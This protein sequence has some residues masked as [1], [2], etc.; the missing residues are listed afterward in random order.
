MNRPGT[1]KFFHEILPY[2]KTEY[3]DTANNEKAVEI[4]IALAFYSKVNYKRGKMLE[5]GATLPYYHPAWLSIVDWNSN[6]K[7]QQIS[8]FPHICLDHTSRLDG[9]VRTK[10]LDY[11]PGN[12]KFSFIVNISSAYS[13]VKRW[14]WDSKEV[15]SYTKVLLWRKTIEKML[16]W[17][18]PDGIMLITLPSSYPYELGLDWMANLIDDM[19]TPNTGKVSWKPDTITKMSRIGFGTAGNIWVQ[20]DAIKDPDL[21][22][23]RDI[24]S[25]GTVYFLVWKG[26]SNE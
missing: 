15:D 21:P 7:N 24:P 16:S 1:F 19:K 12:T 9:V 10:V 6:P 11:N 5:V 22:Y 25:A 4:P 20:K 3:G 23:H 18:S 2:L 26:K 8:S 14:A 13:S 17:L